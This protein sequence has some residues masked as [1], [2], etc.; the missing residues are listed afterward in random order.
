MKCFRWFL[1]FHYVN[2]SISTAFRFYYSVL[3][4]RSNYSTIRMR[5]WWSSGRNGTTIISNQV[6]FI[7]VFS[8]ALSLCLFPKGRLNITKTWK[9]KKKPLHLLVGAFLFFFSKIVSYDESSARKNKNANLSGKVILAM[10]VKFAEQSGAYWE[11][12]KQVFMGM[13]SQ[14]F[15]RLFK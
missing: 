6:K 11:L 12:F 15:S 8:I 5:F 9:K 2:R 4:K 7:C 10:S 14:Q 3:N 13:K 1:I